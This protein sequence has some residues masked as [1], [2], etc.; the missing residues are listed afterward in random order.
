M[1]ESLRPETRLKASRHPPCN[2]PAP[3]RLGH[4]SVAITLDI[5]AHTLPTMQQDAVAAFDAELRRALAVADSS[6]V[7]ASI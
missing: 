5:Y 4:A 1:Q 7:P 6:P 3:E 2:P